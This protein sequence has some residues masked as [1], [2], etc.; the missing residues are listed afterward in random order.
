MIT[1]AVRAVC[2]DI[3]STSAAGTLRVLP[4]RAQI[5]TVFCSRSYHICKLGNGQFEMHRDRIRYVFHR[6]D[7]LVVAGEEFVK[8][9]FL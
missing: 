6:P 4:N 8:Q 9:P 5:S 7:E 2:A 3:T 1:S